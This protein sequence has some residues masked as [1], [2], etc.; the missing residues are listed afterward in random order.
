MKNIALEEKQRHKR[1]VMLIPKIILIALVFYLIVF[2]LKIVLEFQVPEEV[3][4]AAFVN[5]LRLF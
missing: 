1:Q 4:E 5:L 2:I 3:S